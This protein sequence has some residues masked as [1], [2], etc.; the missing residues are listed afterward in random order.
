MIRDVSFDQDRYIAYR[1]IET[2][3]AY[4][5][6]R[7]LDDEVAAMSIGIEGNVKPVTGPVLRGLRICG[8]CL[9]R[10]L[11]VVFAPSDS[12][13]RI[14]LLVATMQGVIAGVAAGGAVILS[15]GF[16][17][18]GLSVG[19]LMAHRFYATWTF[20]V[21]V[22]LALVPCRLL[23]PPVLDVGL[24]GMAALACIVAALVLLQ[25]A[26]QR[27]APVSVTAAL[28][29]MPAVTIASE[30]ASGRAVHWI[31]LVRGA[32]IVLGNLALLVTQ[33]TKRIWRGFPLCAQRF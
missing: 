3:S 28:T 19:E 8:R 2:L 33:R 4:P 7:A 13:G 23:A 16:G 14:A 1:V 22:L 25:Y 9:A 15:R 21:T 18:S 11:V 5:S 27:L 31:V 20:A 24:I 10:P 29:A 12:G 17:S 6:E 32:L 26:T 30:L